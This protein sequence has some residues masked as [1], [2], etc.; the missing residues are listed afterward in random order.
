MDTSGNTVLI[1]GGAT[2]I[3]L[4]AARRLL[5]AGNDV[6]VCGRR[7]DKLDAAQR[8]LPGLKARRCDVGSEPGREA[9]AAWARS[10]HV[11]VLVNNAG[12][13]RM[14]DL[15]QGFGALGAGDNEV[16]INFEGPVYLTA[17]LLPDLLARGEGAVVN[18]TSGLGYV[19]MAIMPVYCATKAAMHLFSVSFRHQL[20]GSGVKVFELI[21]PT[22]DTELD[23]GARARRGQADRGI[24]P[25]EVARALMDGLAGDRFEI[26]V[27][28]AADLVRVSHADF[29]RVFESMNVRV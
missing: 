18:V 24:Q 6:L 13:Q 20:R 2:G 9:L 12:M 22:V 29:E 10:E 3:G 14:V 17:R 27:G 7:Q 16:R 19:P 15:K 23:R 25:D 5:D 11:N 28:R 21:P 8:E 26:A 4:C 1:T